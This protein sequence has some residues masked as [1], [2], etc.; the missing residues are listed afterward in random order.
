MK[1]LHLVIIGIAITG[2]IGP[3]LILFGTITNNSQQTLT[4]RF[5]QPFF[6]IF[7]LIPISVIVLGSVILFMAINERKIRNKQVTFQI[8]LIGSVII[9]LGF[10]VFS[11]YLID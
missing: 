1:T 5:S 6:N 9:F 10:G 4:L 3:A 11:F 7:T 2:G 8:I